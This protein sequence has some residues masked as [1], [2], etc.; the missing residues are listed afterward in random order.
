MSQGNDM[1][2]RE[3]Q[4]QHIRFERLS[5]DHR[6]KVE[7]HI[8]NHTHGD[9]VWLR[10]VELDARHTL[11]FAVIVINKG[12]RG[13]VSSIDLASSG[14]L[15]ISEHLEVVLEDIDDLIALE[16]L[17]DSES[18]SVDELVQLFLELL[19][20]LDLLF[21][22]LACLLTAVSDKVVRII[23]YRLVNGSAE[24]CLG[25]YLLHLVSSL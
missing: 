23:L 16:G 8:V 25:V 2:I 24:V 9:P 1:V 11:S 19:G 6:P 15:L 20:C 12:S 13:H 7:V 21:C 10:W 14:C 17:L 18:N 4:D 22:L 5:L 3:V